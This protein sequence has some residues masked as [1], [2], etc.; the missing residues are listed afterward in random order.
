MRRAFAL[1]A[2]P[3]LM[4][5]LVAAPV[6]AATTYQAVIHE[7]FGRRASSE[8]CTFD[9]PTEVFT[10]PG[11]GTVRGYGRVTSSVAFDFINE[12]TTRTLT[13]GDG[14]TLVLAEVWD[15][16]F[17]PGNSHNAP[18]QMVSWGNPGFDSGVWEVIEGSGQFANASGS[19]TSQNVQAGDTVVLKFVGDIT[20]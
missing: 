15:G 11:W 5:S 20:L 1:L 9:E 18:G 19:G 10:C 4:F 16:F 14:S 17:N 7:D 6:A 8:P 2:I 13:F 12:T 3:G